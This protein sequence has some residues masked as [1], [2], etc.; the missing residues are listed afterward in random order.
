[1]RLVKS[2]ALGL[3]MVAA[4]LVPAQAQNLL[5]EIIQRGSINVGVSL[6]TLPYGMIDA[7]MQPDGHD[8]DVAKLIARDLGVEL[9]IVDTVASNRIPH[10]TSGRVDI[11]ISSFSVTAERA[12]VI[13][14]TNTIYV[15]RQV[16]VAPSAATAASMD[17]LIGKNVG[18]TRAST[19]D[20]VVTNRA[21]E[22]THIQRYDDDASTSQALLAGQVE[23]IVTSGA[24]AKAMAERD[25]DLKVHF[26]VASA[27]M[28]IG[29]ARDQH[30]LLHW[31]NT[32]IFLLDN[33][34][35]LA[36]VQEKWM[37]AAVDELPRF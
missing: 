34:G 22:G 23:G 33:A 26:N 3:A 1:M 13:A 12:K 2:L 11:V 37:G 20:I 6:G 32:D 15:D 29:V 21:K 30:D 18:V 4:T 10:L 28:S 25:P 24:T 5:D 16:Y 35:E 14:F 36:A 27:P 19:N 9:N 7:N 8:V 31:L 17:D